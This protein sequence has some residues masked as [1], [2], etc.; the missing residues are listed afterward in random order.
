MIEFMKKKFASRGVGFYMSFATSVLMLIFALV[1]VLFANADRNFSPAVYIPLFV[2]VVVG[3]AYALIDTKVL[4][5]LPVVSCILYSVAF[6]KYLQLGLETL[7]DVWNG[8]TFN[9]GNPTLAVTFITLFAIGTILS[10]VTSFLKEE[11]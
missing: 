9:G 10:V 5:F 6:G 3:I 8:V 1:Y 7:S 2:G 4:D 11:K